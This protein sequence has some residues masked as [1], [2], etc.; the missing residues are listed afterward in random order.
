MSDES[1]EIVVV[2]IELIE[3][4]LEDPGSFGLTTEQLMKV[5]EWVFAQAE[6]RECETPREEL[7][8]LVG[9]ILGKVR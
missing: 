7:E 3:K 2:A 9:G 1:E 4:L 6:G 8:A 5:A